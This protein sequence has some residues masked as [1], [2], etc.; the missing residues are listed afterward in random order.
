MNSKILEIVNAK[1]RTA[2]NPTIPFEDGGQTYMGVRVESLD[3]ELDSRTYFANNLKL[4]RW[5]INYSLPSFPL[6]DPSIMRIKEELWLTGVKVRDYKGRRVKWNQE[7]YRGN[8]IKNLEYL[9]SGPLG[10]KDICLVDLESKIGVFV[11]PQGKIGGLGRIGYLEVRDI[12]ELQRLSETDWYGAPLINGLFENGTWG[13]VNQAQGLPDGTIGVIG[14]KAYKEI[15]RGDLIKHYFAISF[16]FDP[17]SNEARDLVIIARRS[18]F[19]SSSSKRSPELDDVVYPSG[20][21]G[22]SELYCGLSDFS[23]GVKDIVNPLF[24]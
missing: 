5:G 24:I 2:Y 12:D 6:Q 1:G 13:G 21:Y 14:H 3:S 16:I 8:S 15:Y 9:F 10:M 20:R 23:I 7:F 17:K 18:D 22:K 11:R 19:P 4:N